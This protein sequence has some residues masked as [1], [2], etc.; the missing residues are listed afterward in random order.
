VFP[1]TPP[2]CAAGFPSLSDEI[3]RQLPPLRPAW[4]PSDTAAMAKKP[5]PSKPTTWTI[6]KIASK[7]VWLPIRT[8]QI[9][10]TDMLIPDVFKELC[11][12]FHQDVMLIYPTPEEMVASALKQMHVLGQLNDERKVVLL[13]FLDELL[14]GRHTPAE[15]QEIWHQTTADINFPNGEDLLA[16]LQ[17]IRGDL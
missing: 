7:A 8:T 3:C 4:L 6:Y 14:S 11:R 16:F 15:I 10:L 12:L 13:Q 9:R 17:L 5:D 1:T 2:D